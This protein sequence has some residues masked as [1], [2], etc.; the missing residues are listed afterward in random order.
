MKKIYDLH[1]RAD[2]KTVKKLNK[3]CAASRGN[4]QSKVIRQAILDCKIED[5]KSKIE[6]ITQLKKIGNN[7][8]QIASRIN[9]KEITDSGIINEQISQIHIDLD[10]A[11]DKLYGG[12]IKSPGEKNKQ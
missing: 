2:E 10:R 9:S 8:N 3:M 1:I 7:L 11:L 4:T 5:I 6:I 12:K